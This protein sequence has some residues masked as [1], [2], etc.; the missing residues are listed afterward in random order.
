MSFVGS[1]PA[2][3]LA[4]CTPAIVMTMKVPPTQTAE[5]ARLRRLACT[6]G[7]ATPA[8]MTRRLTAAVLRG[9]EERKIV[10]TKTVDTAAATPNNGQ[11]QP[12]TSGSLNRLRAA[13]GMKV[14]GRMYPNPNA[15]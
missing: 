7:A 4:S 11:A 15:P 1:P 3:L 9:G 5:M 10:V 12:N 2:I 13:A 14:A 8:A 6:N